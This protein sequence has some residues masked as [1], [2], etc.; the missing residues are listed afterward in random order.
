VRVLYVSTA[1]HYRA[2][3]ELAITAI[4]RATVTSRF[5]IETP[6]WGERAELIVLDG[7][8]GGAKPPRE[9][10]RGSAVLDGSVAV[11]AAEPYAGAAELYSVYDGAVK[12]EGIA[13]TDPGWAQESQP[14]VWI[15]VALPHVELVPG[16]VRAHV[17][18]PGEPVRDVEVPDA[19]RDVAGDTLR[20]PLWVDPSLHGERQR[21]SD[22]SNS[23]VHAERFLVTVANLGD[24]PR[25]VW[26][27]EPLRAMRSRSLVKAWPGKAATAGDRVR[28][29]LVIA[30]GKLERVGFVV[31]YGE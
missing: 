3:H 13:S 10:A 27:E 1:L 31:A 7:V 25:E 23:S 18:L 8:P 6:V 15:A 20:L 29:R 22:F 11:L 19:A 26:V 28:A 5:A 16:P 30:P 12:V 24:A 4:D 9:I 2:A 17:E 21:F 14:V